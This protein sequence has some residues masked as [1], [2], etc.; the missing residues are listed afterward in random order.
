MSTEDIKKKEDLETIESPNKKDEILERSGAELFSDDSDPSDLSDREF[1]SLCEHTAI[2]GDEKRVKV[3]SG[4][5]EKLENRKKLLIDANRRESGNLDAVRKELGVEGNEKGA[6]QEDYEK[7][8]SQANTRAVLINRFL[9]SKKWGQQETS[10]SDALFQKNLKFKMDT[11]SQ[12]MDTLGRALYRR[13]GLNALMD[14]QSFSALRSVFAMISEG[15]GSG[16]FSPET[17]A[18]ISKNLMRGFE[19]FGHVQNRNFADTIP[20]LRMVYSSLQGIG[21]ALNEL[22]SFVVQEGSEKYEQTFHTLVRTDD[23][24]SNAMKYVGGRLT[25][26]ERYN[27]ERY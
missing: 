18:G 24:L 1:E 22:R 23:F 14:E 10:E 17:M 7:K 9:E 5:V 13:D 2:L 11:L 4:Y 21:E 19:G 26:V 8:W 12:R 15:L 16:K 6:A 27:A 3:L 25:A 20:S